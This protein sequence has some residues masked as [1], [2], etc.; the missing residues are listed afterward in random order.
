MARFR[1]GAP[2][3]PL[4]VR[5]LREFRLADREE[6]DEAL[7]G[8]GLGLGFTCEVAGPTTESG[9]TGTSMIYKRVL[10]LPRHFLL[11]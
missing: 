1:L 10:I 6:V 7:L 11:Y 3:E 4:L 9:I 2:L 5:R 8:H